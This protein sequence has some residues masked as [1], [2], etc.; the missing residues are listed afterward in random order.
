MDVALFGDNMI[1]HALS[2]SASNLTNAK[3]TSHVRVPFEGITMCNTTPL[4]ILECFYIGPW[5]TQ[6]F[7]TPRHVPSLSYAF[8]AP[9]IYN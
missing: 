4:V 5:Q 8:N 2:L 3:R 1:S 9:L 6:L 7:I